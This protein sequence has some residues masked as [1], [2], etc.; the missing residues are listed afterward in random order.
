MACIR[1][2]ISPQVVVEVVTSSI[3]IIMILLQ[4]CQT[5]PRGIKK[6][7]IHNRLQAVELIF[8]Y[9]NK[10]KQVSGGVDEH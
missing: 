8:V 9:Y 1:D 3:R 4:I 10:N 6:D 7:K 2:P 5:L